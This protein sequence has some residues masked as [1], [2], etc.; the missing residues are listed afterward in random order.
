MHRRAVL[1]GLTAST[2]LPALPSLAAPYFINSTSAAS[3]FDVVAYFTESRP[4]MGH[5]AIAAEHD[6]ARFLFANAANQAAFS[7][8]PARYA[9]Q[10]GG[11]CA[12][13]MAHNAQA[14]TV[15]EA[16]SIVD[17]RLYLNFSLYVREN[18]RR[19]P[20]GFIARAD[21][22]WPNFAA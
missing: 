17:D 5:E 21:A 3:G 15:P 14:S 10:Y 4:V 12:F 19:D 6:G 13:A 11:W 8:D 2:I 16:W 20:A 1:I 22:N 18:W 9:P 7:A